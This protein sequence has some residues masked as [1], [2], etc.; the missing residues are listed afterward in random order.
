MDDF[1]AMEEK[2]RKKY[3][4][5][6]PTKLQILDTFLAKMQTGIDFETLKSF[7]TEIHKIAGSAGTVGYMPVSRIAREF[8]QDLQKKLENFPPDP[9]CLAEFEKIIALIKHAFTHG[10]DHRL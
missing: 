2:W 8:D 6:I 4:A 5:T 1:E 10:E 7:R 3:D 9:S